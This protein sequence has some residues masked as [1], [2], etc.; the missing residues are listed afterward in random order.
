[1]L[2]L[3]FNPSAAMQGDALSSASIIALVYATIA[4]TVVL[5][6]LCC[7]GRDRFAPVFK[8]LMVYIPAGAAASMICMWP[9]FAYAPWLQHNYPSWCYG[10]ISFTFS[11]VICGVAPIVV[12]A[13]L[14]LAFAKYKSSR[15]KNS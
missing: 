11:G 10:F 4:V 13:L 3:A 8:M 12:G 7:C 9:V 5:F 14:L 6:G 2:Y 1:L 15:G